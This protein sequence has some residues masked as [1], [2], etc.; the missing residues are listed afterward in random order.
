MSAVYC[1]TCPG[2]LGI[3]VDCHDSTHDHD[4]PGRVV[5]LCETCGGHVGID[6]SLGEQCD[7]VSHDHQV[8]RWSADDERFWGRYYTRE[9]R[10]Q[11]IHAAAEAKRLSTPLMERLRDCGVHLASDGFMSIRLP[12][13]RDSHDAADA[14]DALIDAARRLAYGD[15]TERAAAR[16]ELTEIQDRIAAL[17][18]RTQGDR[19]S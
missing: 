15:D 13:W 14:I 10:S 2:R 4:P 9:A 16:I 18:T 5:V 6:G 12:D 11:K 19:E 17:R 8:E 1:R 7:D 3:D